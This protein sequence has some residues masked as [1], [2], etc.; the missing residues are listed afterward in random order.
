DR[1]SVNA[2]R[3]ASASSA[4]RRMAKV[5]RRG[6][7]IGR[8]ISGQQLITSFSWHRFVAISLWILVLF[9]IYVTA[10]E[11]SQLFGPAEMRRLLFA[12][13][14]SEL[15]L[16]R[17]QRARELMR[18]NRLADEHGLDEFRDPDSAAHHELVE[19]IERLARA[20]RPSGPD[21]P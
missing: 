16:N 19:I 10:S 6:K 9:L 7:A 17:R 4:P 1:C 20:S 12:Y 13:R 3:M 2:G 18:L 11:F 14:P 5:D 15:Q 21:R 8:A